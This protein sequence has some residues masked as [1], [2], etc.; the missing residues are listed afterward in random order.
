[1]VENGLTPAITVFAA[2]SPQRA[3]IVEFEK[4][5]QSELG[6]NWQQVEDLLKSCKEITGGIDRDIEKIEGIDGDRES[7]E[8][9][10]D[11]K[12]AI[13]DCFL[14]ADGS[15]NNWMIWDPSS[16]EMQDYIENIKKDILPKLNE[17]CKLNLEG[18]ELEGGYRAL[19]YSGLSAAVA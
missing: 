19:G 6:K 13:L 14:N 9:L 12:I 2:D 17:A 8:F 5:K 18:Y 3:E 15:I 11:K 1:M 7:I 4:K 10:R 16:D